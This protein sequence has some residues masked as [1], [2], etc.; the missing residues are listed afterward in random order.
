[1]ALGALLTGCGVAPP[2]M[3]VATAELTSRSDDGFVIT[4]TVEGEN[5]SDD[6]LPLRT[7]NYSVRLGEKEIFRGARSA[8]A[9]LPRKGTQTFRLPAAAPLSAWQGDV[10]GAE[11]TLQAE[12]TYVTPGALAEVLFD[13]GVRQPTVSFSGAG[14]V[15]AATPA[16]TPAAGA[17]G[18]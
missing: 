17:V 14:V 5:V 3:R 6:P 12:M 1:M 11:Y 10:I 13:T 18:P 4:F 8:Q 16:A 2:R 15:L 9:T 7:V